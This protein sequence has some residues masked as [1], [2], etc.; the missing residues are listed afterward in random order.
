MTT[1][2]V[3]NDMESDQFSSEEDSEQKDPTYNPPGIRQPAK[4]FKSSR[5]R[6]IDM[7]ASSPEPES[8]TPTYSPRRGRTPTYNPPVEARSSSNSSSS[9]VLGS[10]SPS[11]RHQVQG[12]PSYS[13]R[14]QTP[15]YSPRLPT[16]SRLVN[17]SYS[18]LVRRRGPSVTRI[19]FFEKFLSESPPQMEVAVDLLYEY[20]ELIKSTSDDKVNAVT[21]VMQVFFIYSEISKFYIQLF[22]M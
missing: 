21:D 13:P 12:S 15:S 22:S 10:P 17:R 9:I 16:F 5:N 14:S 1:L 20:R 8:Y 3:D 19:E 18:P 7:T 6:V 11:P 2:G 4:R